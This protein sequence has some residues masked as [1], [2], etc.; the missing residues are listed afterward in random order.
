M[1][2]DIIESNLSNKEKFYKIA[3][4]LYKKDIQSLSEAERLIVYVDKYLAEVNNGGFDQYFWNTEG[5][6]ADDTLRLLNEL[7]EQDFSRLLKKAIEI[8][9]SEKD[10]DEKYDEFN[11]LDNEFYKLNVKDYDNLYRLCVENLR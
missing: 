10:E 6:F 5:E 1:Y 4:L 3:E 11:E 9:N 2:N 7:N 8:F